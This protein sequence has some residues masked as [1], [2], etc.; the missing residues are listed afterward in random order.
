M[1]VPQL[2]GVPP[3]ASYSAVAPLAA[4]LLTADATDLFVGALGPQWGIFLDGESVI[5]AA[6]VLSFTYK[7]EFAVADYPLEEGSFESY[8]KVQIPFDV[9][10]RFSGRQDLLDSALAIAG[11]KTNFYTAVT[12]KGVYPSCTVTHVDYAQTAT[13]GVDL[14]KVDIWLLNILVAAGTSF[15][16]TAAP[17]G[18]SPQNDGTVQATTY[19]QGGPSSNAS[20]AP[21]NP[22]S[23][24]DTGLVGGGIGMQ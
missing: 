20:G 22:P 21:L 19:A 24:G 2:P 7:S 16:N 3:L 6:N 4:T 5:A 13:D 18:A 8:D 11:D 12:P 9:R 23:S 14:V 15:Q 17:S 10:M 1:G